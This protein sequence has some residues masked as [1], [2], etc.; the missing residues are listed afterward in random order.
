MNVWLSRHHVTLMIIFSKPALQLEMHNRSLGSF[1]HQKR[2]AK[3]FK[4]HGEGLENKEET[5]AAIS[6]VI[7]T[8]MR[9]YPRV[10]QIKQNIKLRYKHV[11]NNDQDHLFWDIFFMLREQKPV[12]MARDLTQCRLLKYKEHML[13]RWETTLFEYSRKFYQK[14][15]I[16]YVKV[17][18]SS[19]QFPLHNRVR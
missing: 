11:D 15:N 18:F 16:R 2:V 1:D 19:S 3:N 17:T 6:N 8:G 4:W 7:F 10:W 9:F 12:G 13:M 14:V 5:S